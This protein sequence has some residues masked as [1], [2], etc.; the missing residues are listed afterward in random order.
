MYT[1]N[2]I[3]SLIEPK[4]KSSK[5]STQLIWENMFS[6][7]QIRKILREEFQEFFT[8]EES[9]S[10]RRKVET[11]LDV[12]GI[13]AQ[14]KHVYFDTLIE[15]LVEKENILD[16]KE[17]LADWI[18]ELAER[19]LLI[20]EP[21]KGKDNIKVW[22]KY[23]LDEETEQVINGLKSLPPMIV[24]P[25][26]TNG[27]N[28]NRGSGYLT[29]GSDSLILNDNYHTKDIDSKFLDLVNSVE[30]SLNPDVIMNIRNCWGDLFDEETNKLTVEY[31]QKL[32]SFEE[33]EKYSIKF[34]AMLVNQDNKFWFTHKYDKR[35][36]IYPMGYWVTYMGNSYQKASIEFANKELVTNEIKFFD[37]S[38]EY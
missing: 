14:R 12:L 8:E 16:S 35:G 28:N 15:M 11:Q 27:K 9:K 13:L 22:A 2:M 3:D 23:E 38:T 17:Q 19:D 7:H 25:L 32:Q 4:D 34:M 1:L 21:I 6:K 36:R 37:N 20:L 18:F 31:K 10:N 29:I 26:E 24:K 33:F 5:I 30:Y